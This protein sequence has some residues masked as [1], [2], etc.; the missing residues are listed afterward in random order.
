MHTC[1]NIY[2][3]VEIHNCIV[4]KLLVVERLQVPPGDGHGVPPG[5]RIIKQKSKHARMHHIRALLG[6]ISPWVVSVAG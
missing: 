6:S 1:M 5:L 4:E 2:L 3:D